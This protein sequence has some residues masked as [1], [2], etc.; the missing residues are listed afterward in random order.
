MKLPIMFVAGLA[1][2]IAFFV[3]CEHAG[4]PANAGPAD[5]AV[6]QVSELDTGECSIDPGASPL[7]ANCTLPAGWEPMSF[8]GAN[9]F[10][11]RCAP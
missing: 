11:R 9:V 10:A 2:G 4:K 1:A 3:A 7:A 8:N 6:W 5:C